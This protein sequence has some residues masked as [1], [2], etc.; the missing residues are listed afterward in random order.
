MCRNSSATQLNAVLCLQKAFPKRTVSSS[1]VSFC[2]HEE[3]LFVFPAF[4]ED[5]HETVHEA[6]PLTSL[7]GRSQQ[8]IL[9]AAT[10]ALKIQHTQQNTVT[11]FLRFPRAVTVS[12]SQVWKQR[13]WALKKH[14]GTEIEKLQ[15]ENK[16]VPLPLLLSFAII[17]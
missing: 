7:V 10:T 3:D 9:E 1:I 4:S 8:T 2:S 17:L 16:L 15:T 13:E 14:Y 6:D 11:Y 5:L 12:L